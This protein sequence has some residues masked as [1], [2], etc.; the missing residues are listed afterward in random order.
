VVL[1]ALK[2]DNLP[3]KSIP[4]GIDFINMD[5]NRFLLYYMT[6][7]VHVWTEDALGNKI[8][9]PEGA[10]AYIRLGNQIKYIGNPSEFWVGNADLFN[11]TDDHEVIVTFPSNGATCGAGFLVKDPPPPVLEAMANHPAQADEILSAYEEALWDGFSEQEA[12][13]TAVAIGQ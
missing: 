11:L 7:F 9:L 12:I 2:N 10:Q 3:G 13:A 8:T 6:D 5:T 1:R 4:Y